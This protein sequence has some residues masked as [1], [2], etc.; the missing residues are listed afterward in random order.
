[1]IIWRNPW[2]H[3]TDELQIFHSIL[4]YLFPSDMHR[5]KQL[6]HISAFLHNICAFSRLCATLRYCKVWL[7]FFNVTARF[8][9]I[10]GTILCVMLC[11]GFMGYD[12][13]AHSKGAHFWKNYNIVISFFN[14]IEFV[15]L[16]SWKYICCQIRS[17]KSLINLLI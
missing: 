14:F 15:D 17:K 11:G 2:C 13:P 12:G 8:K 4:T 9:K 3:Q 1:M 6:R 16:S 10:I 5:Y 7:I